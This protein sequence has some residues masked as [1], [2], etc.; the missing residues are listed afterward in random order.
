MIKIIWINSKRIVFLKTLTTKIIHMILS[1]ISLVSW[2][3]GAFMI[4]VFAVVCVIIVAVVYNMMNSG[5]K[6]E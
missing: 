3:N 6:K 4:G 2:E 5:T 1:N